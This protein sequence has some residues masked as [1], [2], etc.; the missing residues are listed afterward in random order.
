MGD[1]LATMDMHGKVGTAVPPFVGELVPHLTQCRLGRDLPLYKVV[2]WCI[3]PFGHNTYG[4]KMGAVPLFWG[5]VGSLS[6]KMSPGPRPTSLPSG[7]LI[8]PAV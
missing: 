2:S 6:N 4:P 8:H 5:G 3:Q 1:R 7:I